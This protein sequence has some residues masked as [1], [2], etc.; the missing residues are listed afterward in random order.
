MD[1]L[2]RYRRII[3]GDFEFGVVAGGLP[4]VRC[5]VFT[6]LGSAKTARL[7]LDPTSP[8]AAPFDTGDDT[9]FVGYSVSAEMACF[10]RLGWP[11]PTRILDLYAEYRREV[12]GLPG[13]GSKLLHAMAHFGIAGMS[14][15]EKQEMQQLALRGGPY[16]AAERQALLDYCEEDVRGTAALFRAMLPTIDLPRALLR[17]RYMLAVA[18][19]EAAGIPMD[20]DLWSRLRANWE[21]IRGHLIGAVNDSYGVYVP[22]DFREID[23]TTRLGSALLET[24]AHFEINPHRLLDVVTCLWETERAANAEIMEAIKAAR[25]VTGLTPRRCRDWE[26]A[27]RDHTTFP[28]FDVI[29]R[30]LAAECPALGIGRRYEDLDANEITDHGEVLWALL[31]EPAPKVP[32]KWDSGLLRKA[33]EIVYDTPAD[34]MRPSG[35]MRFSEARFAD[36]LVRKNIPWPHLDSGRL[37]LDHETF[38]VMAKAYPEEIGPLRDLLYVLDKLKL[39]E[40]V[41]GPDGRN[42]VPLFPFWSKTGRN[43]PSNA[44]Y[45]FGPAVFLRSLILPPPGKGI[46]YLDWCQQEL[47]IAA[48]LSGDPKMREAYLTGDFYLTFAKMAGAV[49]PDATTDTHEGIRNQFKALALGVLYGLSAVG[50][51]RKL[52]APLTRGQELLEMHRRVFPAYW[53]WSGRVETEAM[54]FSELETCFGWKVN[55]PGGFD[56][57]TRRPL[58]NPRSLRNFMMQ[59]TGGEMMRIACILA[60]ERGHKVCAVIHDALLIEADEDAI[61]AEVEAVQADMR[62]ASELT[63]PGFP[64][65]TEA[66]VIRHP[67]RYS[68]KRGRKMWEI[69]MAVLD[70]VESWQRPDPSLRHLI[71]T[72]REGEG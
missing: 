15:I 53:D 38:R 60:T 22:K 11:A 61:N 40:L 70:R 32:P 33:A 54:M 50:L 65:R 36:F 3:V 35:P 67:E 59:G 46:A 26:D 10:L 18:R 12:S 27:G 19:I 63:L 34:A 51:A 31:R 20:T 9:L 25:K 58:A 44:K 72:A 13:R 41:I 62:E 48:Y 52:D 69:V 57:V 64:L 68:D 4:E 37:A 28:H 56:S 43:Q 55:V 49:P 29:A 66:K 7:W 14:L 23:P 2:R 5:A 24:A 39:R 47:A 45:I 71:V 30:S 8:A 16:T 42:R 6:E 21:A 17:G 1:P